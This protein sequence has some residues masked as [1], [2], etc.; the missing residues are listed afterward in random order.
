M[1][2]LA[3]VLENTDLR[4]SA[5]ARLLALIE[6]DSDII[7]RHRAT[8]ETGSYTQQYIALRETNLTLLTRLLE[9]NGAIRADLH[10]AEQAA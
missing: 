10:V 1:D 6:Q 9:A 3:Q 2:E 8:G 5:I 7:N 4:A